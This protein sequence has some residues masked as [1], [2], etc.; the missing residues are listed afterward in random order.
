MSNHVLKIEPNSEAEKY[1]VNE[2]MTNCKDKV[3]CRLG[4]IY[5]LEWN[6]Y[7]ITHADYIRCQKY[8]EKMRKGS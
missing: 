5:G 6:E 7:E 3:I 8:I 4:I 1:F 2:I